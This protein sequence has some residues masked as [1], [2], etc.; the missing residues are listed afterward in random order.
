MEIYEQSSEYVVLRNT[1]LFLKLMLEYSS[2]ITD[3][4]SVKITPKCPFT[5]NQNY[6]KNFSLVSLHFNT[7]IQYPV[8]I[9]LSSNHW[10]E[11]EIFRFGLLESCSSNGPFAVIDKF[12]TSTLETIVE[13]R[14][15]PKSTIQYQ[16][17]SRQDIA[18]LS[19]AII[20]LF[21]ICTFCITL[22]RNYSLQYY[23]N[24]LRITIV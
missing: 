8:F 1:T 12:Y 13:S 6:Q 23:R 19:I 22:V 18:L 5:I 11:T 20:V 21:G 16:L 17:F 7:T 2:S 15:S 3:L 24:K 9:A 10:I 4:V 14:I